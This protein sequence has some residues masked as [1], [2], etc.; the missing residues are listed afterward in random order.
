MNA[1]KSVGQVARVT[2]GDGPSRS[3]ERKNLPNV[4]QLESLLLLSLGCPDISGFVFLDQNGNAALTNNGLFDPGELPIPN[5]Q[6]ELLSSTGTVLATTT[7]A[8]DGSYSFQGLPN[9]NGTPVTT[10]PVTVTFPTNLTNI[11]NE[12]AASP[13]QLFDPTL[14]TLTSVTISHS[15]TVNSTINSQNTS[16]NSSAD[17]SALLL[18]SYQI[19]GLS[20]PVSGAG[21]ASSGPVTA[22]PFDPANP[23]GNQ[24]PPFN[25]GVSDAPAAVTLTSS[26]DLAFFTASGGRTSITPTFSAT[27]FG[28]ASAPNGNLSTSVT[29][30]ATGSVTV[31][32]TFIP[33]LCIAPG[34]YILEQNPT[35]PGVVDGKASEN[36]LVFPNPGSPQMLPITVTDVDLPNN[37]FGKLVPPNPIPKTCPTPV[38]VVRFGVHQQQT[39]LVLTFSGAVDPTQANNPANY[40]VVSSQGRYIPIKSATFDPATNSVTLIPAQRLNVHYHFDLF[41]NLPC[42]SGCGS[43]VIP[44][45]G[46]ESLGGFTN[47]QGTFVP[48]Q[49][50][51]VVRTDPP[52]HTLS[53]VHASASTHKHKH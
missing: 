38:S 29:T 17:I 37:D 20:Q 49:N 2:R 33:H 13:I 24:I 48:V 30:S 22:G 32:Y 47:H 12:A 40:Y 16:Q 50:A 53:H 5:A 10:T 3:S 31:S 44:F 9:P 7:T 27:G 28:S 15:S 8:A 45:G 6:V 39:Q 35:P 21:Q 19:A 14:G 52:T 43:A 18:A 51:H 4:E 11:G 34:N 25:L 42:T 23:S 1:L 36:G 46:K 41:V 26:A